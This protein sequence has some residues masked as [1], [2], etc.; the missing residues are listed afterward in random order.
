[1]PATLLSV[2]P[3]EQEPDDQRGASKKASSKTC[4]RKSKPDSLKKPTTVKVLILSHYRYCPVTGRLNFWVNVIERHPNVTTH[5][6]NAL[7]FFKI[8]NLI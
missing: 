8:L 1:M 7:I 3:Q 2:N 6:Y 5:R 4:H